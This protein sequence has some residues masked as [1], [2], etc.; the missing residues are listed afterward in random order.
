MSAGMNSAFGVDR[1]LLIRHFVVVMLAVYVLVIHV[2]SSLSPPT[3]THT[4]CIS[5]LLRRKLATMRAY[6]T[7]FPTAHSGVG[8][9][10]LCS[11]PFSFLC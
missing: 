3:V 10:V 6:V 4:L 8:Q 5:F 1:V 7:F 11:F 2:Y 9:S